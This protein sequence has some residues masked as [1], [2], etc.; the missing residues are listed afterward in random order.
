MIP[1]GNLSAA[2]R[3]PGGINGWP[4]VADDLIVWPVGLSQPPVLLALA[5]PD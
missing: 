1:A 3:Y 2:M 4:A 5:L